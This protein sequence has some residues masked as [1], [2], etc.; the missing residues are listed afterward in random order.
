[1]ISCIAAILML[2]VP[3]YVIG[4]MVQLKILKSE[5]GYAAALVTGSFVLSA[6]MLFWQMITVK[7]LLSFSVMQWGTAACVVILMAVGVLFTRRSLFVPLP[8]MTGEQKRLLV[9]GVFLFLIQICLIE[10]KNPYFGNDMTVEETW[11][12]LI[13][14]RLCAYHPGTGAPLKLGMERMAKLDFLPG[15]YA[16]LCRFSKADPYVLICRFVPIFGLLFHYAAVWLL[17]QRF[18]GRNECAF[19]MVLYEVLLICTSGQ[20]NGIGFQLLHQGWSTAVLFVGTGA[21]AVLSAILALADRLLAFRK[22]HR[23]RE[24]AAHETGME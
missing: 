14:N 22:R 21:P 18:L 4:R 11:T 6:V 16:M 23:N 10:W 13:T 9:A 1:M 5:T 8:K 3:A 15:M 7:A 2:S 17:L 19:S 12:V 24:V 20:R